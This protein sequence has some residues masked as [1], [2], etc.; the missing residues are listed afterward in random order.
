MRRKFLPASVICASVALAS[1]TPWLGALLLLA[2]PPVQAQNL[3]FLGKAPAGQF[4]K[5]DWKLLQQA[6]LAALSDTTDGTTHSWRN[7]SNQHQGTVRIVKSWQDA[8]G[9]TCRRIHL[10]NSAGGYK[11]AST[12]DACKQADG[13]WVTQDGL[14]LSRGA[15]PGPPGGDS[16][17]S[18]ETR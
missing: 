13:I 12:N 15:Q 10:D 6:V 9:R 4:N 14:R 2:E 16:G 5:T 1:A 8:Q 17:A 11:G 7:D 18:R 3:N